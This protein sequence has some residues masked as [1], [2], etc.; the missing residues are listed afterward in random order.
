M[1]RGRPCSPPSCRCY[2]QQD[3]AALPFFIMEQCPLLSLWEPAATLGDWFESSR[4]LPMTGPEDLTP[5]WLWELEWHEPAITWEAGV[6]GDGVV[7]P[8]AAWME[9]MAA[10]AMSEVARVSFNVFMIRC[11]GRAG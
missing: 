9:A 6:D 11:P 10:A 8:S 2:L 5:A 1:A 7:S 3:M 4:G